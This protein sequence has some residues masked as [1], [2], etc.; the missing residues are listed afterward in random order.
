MENLAE[1]IL[2]IPLATETEW[3]IVILLV[4]IENGINPKSKFRKIVSTYKS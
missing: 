1:Q 3:T 2:M 4:G